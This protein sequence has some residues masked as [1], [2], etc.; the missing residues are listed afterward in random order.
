MRCNEYACLHG[1]TCKQEDYC[2]GTENWIGDYCGTCRA[3]GE[4][5][6]GD[7]T[8]GR[9]GG[10]ILNLAELDFVLTSTKRAC[11]ALRHCTCDGHWDGLRSPHLQRAQCYRYYEANT[12]ARRV[13]QL[14][15]RGFLSGQE[16]A[17]NDCSLTCD[18]ARL[19]ASVGLSE[20]RA[21]CGCELDMYDMVMMYGTDCELECPVSANNVVSSGN[22]ECVPQWAV[23]TAICRCSAGYYGPDCQ[24]NDARCGTHGRCDT[25]KDNCISDTQFT[26]TARRASSTFAARSA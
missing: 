7:G 15:G 26:T 25:T 12:E 5:L 19:G 21:E 4:V 3:A 8:A 17:G 18:C 9:E 13:W 20:T 24:G 14:C 10:R 22:G 6:L 16:Y 11:D 2:E 23:N 1:G